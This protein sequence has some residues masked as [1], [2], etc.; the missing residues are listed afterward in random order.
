[1]KQH[2]M[3][4]I[5]DIL[6]PIL[7][8]YPQEIL[9]RNKLYPLIYKISGDNRFGKDYRQ[10]AVRSLIYEHEIKKIFDQFNAIGIKAI[11]LR[12]LY[13]GIEI[14]KEPVLRPFTDID[15][16]VEKHNVAKAKIALK[17]LG[18]YYNPSL[19]SE[20][21]FLESHLH[22]VYFQLERK[23]AC[24]VHWAIDH[25]FTNYDIKMEEI[26]ETAA[27]IN[28]GGIQC[29]DI[30]PEI[31]FI[32]LLIHIQKHLPYLKYQ[33]N[34]PTLIRKIAEDG[35]LLHILDAY[36]FLKRYK[37]TFNW[38]LFTEKAIDW[39]VDGV[40]Y[41]TLKTVAK[42]FNLHLPEQLFVRLQPPVQRP[43]EKFLARKLLP[44]L[45]S[46]RLISKISK[47]LIFTPK[48]L[49]DL[50][51]WFFPDRK[52]IIR[53]YLDKSYPSTQ[54]LDRQIFYAY[55]KNFGKCFFEI[56]NLIIKST[57]HSSTGL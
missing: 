51:T 13:L 57:F 6:K 41:S 8:A 27:P 19:F 45:N 53:K 28:L 12:G 26:F 44:L 29:F 16:L 24:E 18:Y 32:L 5:E 47:R 35:E 14:Y 55:L 49:L 25:P 10:S 15:V 22:L 38:P 36:L 4:N 46:N 20:E 2:I 1:M 50:Y 23:I 30:K 34:E 17:N 37:G 52:T 43:L 39:N 21:F 7:E 33:Y 11:L 31:R 56:L 54:G 3:G 9:S 42:I 48:R 40:M